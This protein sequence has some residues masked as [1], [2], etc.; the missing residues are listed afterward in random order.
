LI[1]NALQYDARN[2]RPFVGSTLCGSKLE[3]FAGNRT[4]AFNSSMA[5]S[6]PAGVGRILAVCDYKCQKI[7]KY[8]LI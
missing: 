8:R 4:V 7:V 5:M 3:G 2:Q 1:K 6:W